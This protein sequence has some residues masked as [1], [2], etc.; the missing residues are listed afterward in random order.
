M[1]FGSYNDVNDIN[2]IKACG[3]FLSIDSPSL[4]KELV[5]IILSKKAVMVW[6]ENQFNQLWALMF[7]KFYIKNRGK[8]K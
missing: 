5:N 7:I 8:V 1:A 6:L 3:K 4:V 2:V